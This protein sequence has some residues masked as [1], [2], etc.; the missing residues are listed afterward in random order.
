MELN[1]ERF[2]V[3]AKSLFLLGA[4]TLD[5]QI[6]NFMKFF[7]FDRNSPRFRII[8]ERNDEMHEFKVGKY[9]VRNRPV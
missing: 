8:K 9:F 2:Q 7:K 4:R 6:T 5:G 1:R 3:K